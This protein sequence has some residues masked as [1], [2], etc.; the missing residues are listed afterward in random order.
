[1]ANNRRVGREYAL[2]MLFACKLDRDQSNPERLLESFW[3]QFRFADD[4][5]GEPLDS[6]DNP[7]P[8]ATRLFAEALVRG[9]VEYC[10]VIDKKIVEVAKNWSLERMAP[11]DLS[12]LRLAAYELLYRPDIPAR[13]TINEAIEIA[14]RYGTKDSP[15]FINGLLD[16]IAPQGEETVS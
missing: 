6:V 4:V 7:L 3:G 12:I 9:V 13:V 10:A 5:L 15:A 1:M 2:K 14:K 16:K 11:V 8:M